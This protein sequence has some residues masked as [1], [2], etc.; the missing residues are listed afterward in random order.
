MRSGAPRRPVRFGLLI[1]VFVLSV[2][3]PASASADMGA[4]DALGSGAVLPDATSQLLAAAAVPSGF[5]ETIAFNGLTNPTVVRFASDGRIFVAEKS[6]RIKV[7]D[8]FS[9]TTPTIY[10]DLSSKVQDYGDRGLLGRALD[11]QSPSRPYVYVLYAYDKDPSSSQVPR[12][13]DTCP[14]PPGPTADGCVVS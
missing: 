4:A 7:F 12:G 8:N 1:A 13:G 6:G 14:T 2:A 3:L 11:P 5:Q 9:D 10:A